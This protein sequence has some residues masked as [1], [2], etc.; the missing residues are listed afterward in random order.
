MPHFV[1][2]PPPR[3]RL[4]L[5]FIYLEPD[6]HLLAIG[7][8]PCRRYR[9]SFGEMKKAVRKRADEL[10][11]A[12][13]LCESRTQAQAYILAGKVRM[14]TQRI[15]KASRLLPADSILC[16]EQSPRFVG[17]GGLKMRYFLGRPKSKSRVSTYLTSGFNGRIHRLPP[18]GRSGFG[19]L[20]R[21]GTRTTSLQAPYRLPGYEPRE[22]K[23]AS[24]DR[25]IAP[26]I[27]VRTGRDGPFVY[28]PA[29]SFASGVV[30]RP[31]G[32]KTDRISQTPIRMR[33]KGSRS[34]PRGN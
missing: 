15:D 31:R 12:L 16:L 14:G 29:Q 7:N 25:K 1:T 33:Q 13:G 19:H 20:R 24:L 27:F 5:F 2:L 23:P 8:C 30:F 34:R 3:S 26:P 21:R 6:T 22:N 4:F 17:R 11:V 18:S 32:R 28:L 9:L 10:V